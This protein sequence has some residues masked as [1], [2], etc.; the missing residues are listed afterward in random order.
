MTPRWWRQASGP[1]WSSWP[2]TAPAWSS[3]IPGTRR[4]TS[5]ISSSA[6][7]RRPRRPSADPTSGPT[8]CATSSSTRPLGRGWARRGR[9]PWTTPRSPRRAGCW[10]SSPTS[11]RSIGCRAKTT[12]A[13]ITT[14]PAR[15]SWVSMDPIRAGWPAPPSAR[16]Q[17]GRCA[18]L[19]AERAR[20]LLD[21]DR[22]DTLADLR[23]FVAGYWPE[24]MQLRA[25]RAADGLAVLSLRN[26]G[27]VS[28]Y[29]TGLRLSIDGREHRPGRCGAGQP[30]PRRGGHTRR[31]GVPRPGGR[32][33]HPPW[34]DRGAA[35]VGWAAH[36][37]PANRAEPRTG[38]RLDDHPRGRVSG[39]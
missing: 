15:P 20:R 4:L 24:P 32:L 13:S 11:W 5:S 21:G 17:L 9:W 27:P 22:I 26:Q 36:R 19:L 16:Q 7:A 3:S 35:A 37:S 30:N 29:L 14:I 6:S 8:A 25:T 10:P 1:A 12:I 34:S 28:R 23:T 31:G 33:L 2:S 39:R 18:T 38:G